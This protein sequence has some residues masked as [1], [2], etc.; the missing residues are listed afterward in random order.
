MKWLRLRE[1]IEQADLTITGEGRFDR[2]SLQGKGTG[3]MIH[4]SR[5]GQKVWI[6]AGQVESDVPSLLPSPMNPTSTIAISPVTYP[7]KRALDEGPRLLGKA[8]STKIRAT[9]R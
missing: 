4:L 2:S 1:R 3:T 9:H 8:V 5:E 7:L 6:F